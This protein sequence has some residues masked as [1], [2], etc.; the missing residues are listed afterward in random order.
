MKP[1]NFRFQKKLGQNF[2]QD[3]ALL[4]SILSSA[5]IQKDDTVLEIGSGSGILTEKLAVTA[6]R[7]IALEIDPKLCSF[8]KDRFR[9]YENVTILEQDILKFRM[10]TLPDQD[11]KVVANLPYYISTPIL[12]R[13]FQSIR[14]FSFILVMLQK[15]LAERIAAGP[16]TK[17]YGSLSIVTRFYTIPEI[18]TTV[19]RTAF[20]PVPEVDSALMRLTVRKSPP[21]TVANP[22]RFLHF[23]RTAFAQRRK[24]LRNSLLRSGFVPTKRLD[25]AFEKTGIDPTRRAETL[26]IEEFALLSQFLL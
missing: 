7:V 18:I 5:R 16:G 4:D 22:E 19:P 8:L 23:V 15:E 25:T 2:L 11:V 10:E 3:E 24:T 14:R 20:H 9:N 6:G 26:S 12:S 17:K 13:L 21:V 1:A